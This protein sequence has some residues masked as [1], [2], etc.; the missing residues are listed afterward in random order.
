M[1][2]PDLMEFAV[3]P[4][5]QLIFKALGEKL[6]LNNEQIATQLVESFEKLDPAKQRELMESE[7]S[8]GDA[9][10]LPKVRPFVLP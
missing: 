7:A 5:A 4:R 6:Q 3:S 2:Q 8:R 10:D 1:D 9:S